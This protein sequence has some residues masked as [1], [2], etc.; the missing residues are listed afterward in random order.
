MTYFLFIFNHLYDQRPIEPVENE[1][2][3]LN[4]PG[5]QQ[6]NRT[7]FART[8]RR[9]DPRFA[10]FEIDVQLILEAAADT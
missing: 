2:H 9:A 4:Y 3:F 1:F 10:S 7:Q 8:A 5:R 6:S